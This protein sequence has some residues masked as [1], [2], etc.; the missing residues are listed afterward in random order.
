MCSVKFS[1]VKSFQL[2][3][4]DTKTDLKMPRSYGENDS[5][6]AVTNLGAGGSRKLSSISG[7]GNY[8][9]L[10]QNI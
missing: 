3:K 2:L 5:A 1:I 6:S 10:L 8:V 4:A 7:R 9:S